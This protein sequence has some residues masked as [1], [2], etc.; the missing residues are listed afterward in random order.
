MTQEKF[1]SIYN[2]KDIKKTSNNIKE[3]VFSKEVKL[4]FDK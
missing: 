3:N 1:D 2:N 4:G